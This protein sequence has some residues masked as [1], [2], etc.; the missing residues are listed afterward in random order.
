MDKLTV[1][2]Y[3]PESLV[4]KIDSR[5]AYSNRSKQLCDDLCTFYD[6][7]DSSL[8]KALKKLTADDLKTV[9]LCIRSASFISQPTLS[10]SKATLVDVIS[11]YS[12]ADGLRARIEKFDDLTCFALFDWARANN[13]GSI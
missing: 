12:N 6:I 8:K 7:L 4:I 1:S 10:A 9:M 13:R 3:L 2:Y 11:R 5:G